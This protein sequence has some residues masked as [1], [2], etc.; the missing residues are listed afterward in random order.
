MA[1]KPRILFHSLC[2]YEKSC[3]LAMAL[4]QCYWPLSLLCCFGLTL[5]SHSRGSSVSGH[6]CSWVSAS[7]GQWPRH[8]ILTDNCL[9]EPLILSMQVEKR[10]HYTP[11]C[12]FSKPWFLLCVW[13]S[14]ITTEFSQ[15]HLQLQ[16]SFLCLEVQIVVEFR[17]QEWG[18]ELIKCL[19]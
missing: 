17:R 7:L 4:S 1:P 8:W 16:T 19:I 6:I 13:I 9:H 18:Q 15:Q 14:E 11:A 2:L 10:G 3:L 5:T 12:A